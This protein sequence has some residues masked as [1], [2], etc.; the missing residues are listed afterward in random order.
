[1]QKS[2]GA[3][4]YIT[5]DIA[6]ATSRFEEF[7]FDQM[8]YVVAAQQDLHFQQLFKILEMLGKEY[9]DKVKHINFGMVKGMSTRKGNVVFL[10]DILQGAKEA[11]LDVMKANPEKFAEIEDPEETAY[12]VGLSAVVVQDL[13]AKRIKDYDFSWER[14]CSFEVSLSIFSLSS[15]PSPPPS[16][17]LL[18]SPAT[19]HFESSLLYTGRHRTIPPVSTRTTPQL[20]AQGRRARDAGHRLHATQRTHRAGHRTHGRQVSRC[21]S[22]GTPNPRACNGHNVSL[23]PCAPRVA[24]AQHSVGEE[25]RDEARR[26]THG[27]VLGCARHAWQWLAFA[28]ACAFRTYVKVM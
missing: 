6:A 18:I 27:V 5:R 22:P 26:G 2:D 19:P 7:K 23:R 3:T 13:S 25:P 17:S 14:V 1:M 20:V 15:T 11:M 10:S 9:A 4:L 28:W 8:I 12:I 24:G 16:P 21:G